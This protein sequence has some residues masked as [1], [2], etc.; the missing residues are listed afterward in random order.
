MILMSNYHTPVLLSEAIEG[1]NVRTDGIYVDVTFGGGGHSAAIL[2]KL[3]NGRLIAM[4]KDIEALANAPDHPAL[5]LVN[6]DFSWMRNYLKFHNALPVDGILADLGVSSH[7][8]NEARRG[9]SYRYNAELDMRMNTA[10]T[11]TAKTIVNEYTENELIKIF[12]TYGEIKNARKIAGI[13]VNKRKIKPIQTT[14]D[15]VDIIQPN[16]PG[17][18]KPFKFLSKVFQAIRIE[19]NDELGVLKRFL[20]QSAKSLK[21]GGRL[22]VISYHSLEDRM[23][24]NFISKGVFE[25]NVSKDFYG[26][27][28]KP[29]KLISRKAIIPQEEEINKNP[30]ARSAKLRIAEK[31]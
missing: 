16:I 15:L 25:G 22:V 6:G 8:F 26:N 21:S 9:F 14:T 30:A 18:I 13:I 29:F 3:T 20:L 17:N 2:E 7:H 19:V 5:T 10:A 1:L 28:I 23:V 27:E 24:K 4:D 11:L 31:I 12:K